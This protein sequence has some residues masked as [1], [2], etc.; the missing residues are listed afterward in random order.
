MAFLN[1]FSRNS[2]V[3]GS[4]LCML[5]A[6]GHHKALSTTQAKEACSNNAFLKKYQC[7]LDKIEQAA[8]T[9]DPDAEYALGY[10]YYYGIDTKQDV[11]AA[12]LWMKRAAAQ[13]QPQAIQALQLLQKNQYQ[14]EG[15]IAVNNNA[16]NVAPAVVK[17]VPAKA[18][19]NLKSLN[20]YSIQLAASP[21]LN[22][23]K[24]FVITN[25][26]RGKAGYY[27]TCMHQQAWYIL[28][29]GQYSSISTAVQVVHQ[30]PSALQT[31]H[32]W[33]KSYK[34]IQTQIAQGKTC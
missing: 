25:Q 16:T 15:Q 10:M 3:L 13:G 27:K 7:S 2:L 31:Q 21:N 6:C 18:Q 14:T 8:E 11:E 19:V 9:Y 29:Y 23:I 26:L 28:I 17:N 5:A 33:V 30:L 1:S 4:A 12:K 34:T 20:G 24:Q 32:P 22:R